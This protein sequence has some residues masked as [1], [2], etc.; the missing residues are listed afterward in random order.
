MTDETY[1]EVMLHCGDR[2]IQ[3]LKFRIQVGAF[4]NPGDVDFHFLRSHDKI[5]REILEDGITRFTM[6]LYEVLNEADEVRAAIVSA[7]VDDAWVVPYYKKKRISIAEVKAGKMNQTVEEVLGAMAGL[8]PMQRIAE[9]NEVA[10]AIAFLAS[11]R[12]SYI[13]GINIPVDGGRTK[14][15]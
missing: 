11:P 15:L 6:G 3:K 12:A 2:P 7:G 5:R 9:P 8:S 1:Q 4:K 13:N 10:E 14:S